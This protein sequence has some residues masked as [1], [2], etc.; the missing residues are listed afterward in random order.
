MAR[1]ARMAQMVSAI[2]P[3]QRPHNTVGSTLRVTLQQGQELQRADPATL[4]QPE[5][6]QRNQ[7][8]RG[9]GYR[10]YALHWSQGLGPPTPTLPGLPS[11]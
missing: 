10:R 1:M 2:P 5:V 11:S 9:L 6:V 3:P 7:D 4:L 8:S